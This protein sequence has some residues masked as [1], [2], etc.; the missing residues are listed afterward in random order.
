MAVRTPKIDDSGVPRCDEDCPQHDGKRCRELGFR[1]EG[2]CEPEVID[3]V[4]RIRAIEAPA[5]HFVA[6]P[7]PGE[8]TTS[9][10]SKVTCKTCLLRITRNGGVCQ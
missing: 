7:R 4:R 6:D 3:L 5:I 9:D 8:C 2:I 10:P 1:P